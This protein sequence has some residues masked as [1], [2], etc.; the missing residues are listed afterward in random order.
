MLSV[1]SDH[2][3][4][5]LSKKVIS[6]FVTTP[7]SI[8]DQTGNTDGA[9]TGWS[10]TSATMPAVHTMQHVSR[11]VVTPIPRVLQAGQWTYSPAG[12][13]MAFLTGKLAANRARKI[14]GR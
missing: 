13:P 7:V 12:L 3:Y 6:R 1:L 10:F 5:D 14:R 9:I 4:P 11:S 2:L 8:E